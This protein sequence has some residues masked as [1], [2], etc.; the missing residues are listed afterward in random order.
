VKTAIIIVVLIK[1]QKYSIFVRTA[2][3]IAVLYIPAICIFEAVHI[4][5][6][7]TAGTI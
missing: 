5:E 4:F 1:T 7:F 6:A 2:I 3:I